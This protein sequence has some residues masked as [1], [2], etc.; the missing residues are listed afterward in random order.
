MA[1]CQNDAYP[2]TLFW[3]EHAYVFKKMLRQP[4]AVLFT[5]QCVVPQEK[6]DMTDF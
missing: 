2:L 3:V 6:L 5:S 4:L 1:C